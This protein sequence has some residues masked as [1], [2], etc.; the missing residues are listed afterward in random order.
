[1]SAKR[2]GAAKP[3]ALWA[4]TY[5]ATA[6]EAGADCRNVVRLHLNDRRRPT[7]RVLIDVH[8]GLVAV[9]LGDTV[10]VALSFPGC[11][12]QPAQDAAAHAAQ[13]AP[14]Y[15]M[16]GCVVDNNDS[17]LVLSFGGLVAMLMWSPTAPAP[18][19]LRCL[20]TSC[21]IECTVA[22]V[23][24]GGGTDDLSARPAESLGQDVLVSS[25]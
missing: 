13:L 18:A 25:S 5:R 11:K 19:S 23:S 17:R 16:R 22:A 6:I 14:D 4:R 3:A 21:E 8:A 2:R 12:G 24:G 9:S 7:D 15:C 10:D 1:M 20:A